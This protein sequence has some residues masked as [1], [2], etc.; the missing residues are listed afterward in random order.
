MTTNRSRL[1]GQEI[2]FRVT[3][4]EQED[5]VFLD[6]KAAIQYLYPLNFLGAV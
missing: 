1:S 3:S 5:T 4:E 2:F 6:K